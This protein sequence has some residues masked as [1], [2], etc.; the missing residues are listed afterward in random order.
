MAVMAS[1]AWETGPSMYMRRFVY[2]TVLT[3][4]IKVT[5]HET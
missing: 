5:A 1:E 3:I 4:L 2:S